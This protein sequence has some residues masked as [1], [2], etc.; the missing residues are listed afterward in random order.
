MKVIYTRNLVKIY[1]DTTLIA[2]HYRIFN[3]G[4]YSTQKQHLC[5]THQHY[6]Q[7]SPIYYMQLAYE[8]SETL[9]QYIKALF[10]QDKYP[11]QLY[12][13]CDGILNLAKYSL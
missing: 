8:H 2:T 1:A 7:R 4:G 5:S 3:K 11:E 13:S 9:Y 12:R 6:K 10:N